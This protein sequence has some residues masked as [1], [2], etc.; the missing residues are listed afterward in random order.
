MTVNALP[1]RVF[2]IFIILMDIILVIM[3][4]AKPDKT[5]P[6]QAAFDWISFLTGFVFVA[7]VGGRLY[8]YGFERYFSQGSQTRLK[9]TIRRPRPP[10]CAGLDIPVKATLGK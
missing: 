5:S 8:A 10:R 4:L 3:D 7:D 2:V 1:T 6:D 9:I